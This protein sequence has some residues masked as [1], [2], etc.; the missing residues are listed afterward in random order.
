MKFS[1]D[2]ECTPEEA[3]AFFGMPSVEALNKKLTEEIQARMLDHVRAMDP[4]ALA[5]MWLPAGAK[6]WEQMQEAFTSAFA[7]GKTD[8]K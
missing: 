4:D 3:R 5:K 1:I 8:K 2:I 6:A 7:R